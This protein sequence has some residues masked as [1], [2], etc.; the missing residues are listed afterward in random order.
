MKKNQLNAAVLLIVGVMLAKGQVGVGT[1]SPDPS[2]NLHVAPRNNSNQNLGTLLGTMTT[3]NR[4]SIAQPATGLMIYNT[5]DNCLQINNGTPGSPDWN[6]LSDQPD[7][8]QNMV[9]GYYKPVYP[10]MLSSNLPRNSQSPPPYSP[11]S[12]QLYG[13]NTAN[14]NFASNSIFRLEM[15]QITGATAGTYAAILYNLSGEVIRVHCNTTAA[16]Q[17]VIKYNALLNNGAGMFVDGNYAA[18]Y[19]EQQ[20]VYVTIAYPLKWE[21]RRFLLGWNTFKEDYATVMAQGGSGTG[22]QN[23]SMISYIIELK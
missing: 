20:N 9:Y 14:G 7:S 1:S 2:T 19:T 18:Y 6:C 23:Q 15:S 17:P 10:G 3:Q 16:Y 4:N 11:T 13:S 8:F 5:T 21:G 22:K 12:P